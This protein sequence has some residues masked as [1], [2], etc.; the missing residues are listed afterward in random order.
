MNRA[1]AYF[2]VGLMK[3][4]TTYLQD[5]VLANRDSLAESG[6]HFAG[7]VWSRQVRAAQDLM[8]LDQDDPRIAALSVGAWDELVA[9]IR[10]RRD[11]ATL[12][13]MEFLSFAGRRAL[14]RIAQDL[15]DVDLHVI[16]TVRDVTS[17]IPAQW[18]TSVTSGSTHTWSDFQAG[19]QRSTSA[20]WPV[21]AVRGDTGVREF[22]RTQDVSRVLRIWG[23]VVPPERLH[24]VTVP[25]DRSEPDVLWR[26]FAT[27][28]GVDPA[29]APEPARKTNPSLGDASTELVRRLNVA[30]E[31]TLTWDLNHTIKTPLA[32]KVLA[33]RRG[34][35]GR[36]AL[37]PATADFARSWNQR[38]REAVRR[39]GAQLV[40]SLDDL[41][42]DASLEP[43]GAVRTGGGEPGATEVLVAARDAWEGLV[44][45][46]ERRRRR[47]ASVMGANRPAPFPSEPPGWLDPASEGTADLDG[48]VRDLAVLCRTAIQLRRDLLEMREGTETDS[49]D[50]SDDA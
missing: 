26:R 23:R 48:A 8:H 44:A 32:A 19:V 40:G 33:A 49:G 9:E 6:I 36:P 34:D 37:A 21:H 29:R 47:L 42:I 2:H 22:R 12:V 18:Q 10:G 20:L 50:D 43:A 38:S 27:A 31:G 35:E 24:V 15:A 46:V 39:S 25:L 16:V 7:A 4:G 11:G 1:V 45:L 14:N 13:S 41:P 5:R 30:L 28:L 3:T 17:T